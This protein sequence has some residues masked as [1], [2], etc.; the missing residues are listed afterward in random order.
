MITEINVIIFFMM[1]L[2]KCCIRNQAILNSSI[3]P[4]LIEYKLNLF[5]NQ[6]HGFDTIGG[7]DLSNINTT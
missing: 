2:L 5:S 4:D 1:V 3:W 6:P 7:I